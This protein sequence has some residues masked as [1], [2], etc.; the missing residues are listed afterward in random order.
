M[1]FLSKVNTFNIHFKNLKIVIQDRK[2]EILN[3]QKYLDQEFSSNIYTYEKMKGMPVCFN[4]VFQLLHVDSYK[5][6][7]LNKNTDS[8][9]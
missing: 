1:I 7:R 6:L 9:S 8:F 3:L 5:F 4:T 2:S